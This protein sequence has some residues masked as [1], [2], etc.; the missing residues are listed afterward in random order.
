MTQGGAVTYTVATP[1]MGLLSDR[2]VT[3]E[4]LILSGNLVVI[5]RYSMYCTPYLTPGISYLLMGPPPV[6]TTLLPSSY[7]W[8]TT[9]VAAQ[10]LT[11]NVQQ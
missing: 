8:T 7:W 2:G 10:V 3:E 9:S 1:V 6:L 4:T 5:S 11:K